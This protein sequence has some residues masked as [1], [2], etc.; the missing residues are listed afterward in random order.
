[1][2]D[3]VHGVGHTAAAA[4]YTLLTCLQVATTNVRKGLYTTYGA[5]SSAAKRE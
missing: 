5:Q 3:D 4:H 1:M 2:A